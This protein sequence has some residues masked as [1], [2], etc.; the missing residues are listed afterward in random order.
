MGSDWTT[1]W[2]GADEFSDKLEKLEE[3]AP[4]QFG[5]SLYRQSQFVMGVS[6]SMT[7]R[8]TGNLVGSR[9]VAAPKRVGGR[10]TVE[11]G[12]GAAYALAV[13][14]MPGTLKGQPRSESPET[15]QGTGRGDHWDP[16]AEP[17]FLK[18]AIQ[19][20]SS[21]FVDE[22]IEDTEEFIRTGRAIGKGGK[23]HPTSPDEG[24]Q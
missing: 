2:E 9:F 14:E 22:L 23:D 17:E 18:K 11:V 15:I 10:I 24:D 12:Y 19:K 1:E 20:R 5:A 13:H 3:E 4:E 7:P 8:D 16:D 6:V 21:E